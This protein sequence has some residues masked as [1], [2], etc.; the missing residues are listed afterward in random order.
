MNPPTLQLR[1]HV[2]T[3]RGPGVGSVRVT[4]ALRR[5]RG[6]PWKLVTRGSTAVKIYATRKRGPYTIAWRDSAAG[7]RQRAMRSDPFVAVSFAEQ[8][9]TELANGE[10]WR[11]H[12]TQADWASYQR[13]LQI[14][15]PLKQALELAEGIY[16]DAAQKLPQGISLQEV[17]RVYLE[18]Q[19]AG[20]VP[21]SIPDLVT[22]LLA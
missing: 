22:S 10:A 3:Q 14:L 19:P 16:T 21:Q 15:A 12:L 4:P 5:R 11:G 9:A 2:P 6:K 8:K 20:G 17:V 1:V 18:H 13:A 7:R